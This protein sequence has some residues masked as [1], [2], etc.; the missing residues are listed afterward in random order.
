MAEE[1]VQTGAETTPEVPAAA[2]PA[3]KVEAKPTAETTPETPAK[4]PKG[5]EDAPAE[6]QYEP[7]GDAKLDVALAFF[8][9]AGLDADHPAIKAAVDGDFSLLA[10][11]LEEKGIAGWQ[12]H[13]ALAKESHEKFKADREASEGKIVEAVVG[14]LEKAGYTN[15]Q[16]G[17]AI[18]WAREN[19]EPEELAALNQMLGT[20]F[21]AKAAVAYLTGLHREASGVEYAPQKQAVKDE[22]GSTSRSATA[23]TTP[24]SRAEFA[25]E[26]EK[27]AKKFGSNEYMTSP[28]YRALRARVK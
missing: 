13:L 14:A 9:R 22:A 24:L 21:G 15:E 6:I 18:G 28:E 1:N 17:E 2:A 25:R 16:W 3:I 20:P 27:L 23:D 12:S 5:K 8:G 7:T 11:A 10:A 26:A 4:A 19:A